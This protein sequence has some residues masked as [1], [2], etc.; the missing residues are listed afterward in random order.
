MCI[1]ESPEKLISKRESCDKG[2]HLK[3]SAADEKHVKGGS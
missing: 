1:K 2:A 3:K